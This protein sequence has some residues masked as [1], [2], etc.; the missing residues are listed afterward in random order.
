MDSA[1]HDPDHPR[2]APRRIQLAGLAIGFIGTVLVFEPWRQTAPGAISGILA[3]LA[4]ASLYGVSYVY[5]ARYVTTLLY[6]PIALAAG[7]LAA[8]MVLSSPTRRHASGG[9]A[10]I[11]PRSP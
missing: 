10:A 3:C 2:A 5:L 11:A 1:D 9:T 6:N 8:A 7:Q 4:A